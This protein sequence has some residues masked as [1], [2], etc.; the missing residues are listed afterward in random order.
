MACSCCNETYDFTK[1][2]FPESCAHFFNKDH[3][4]KGI[5]NQFNSHDDKKNRGSCLICN[6]P[7]TEMELKDILG[8][9]EYNQI[10]SK[11]LEQTLQKTSVTCIK[12]N[13]T[14]SFEPGDMNSLIKG[15]DNKPL[16]G[17][18]LKWYVENRFKCPTNNCGTE[19]C[20]TCQA[21]PYHI[22]V[23]C[24]EYKNFTPCRYCGE[25][26]EHEVNMKTNP[27]TDICMYNKGCLE[28]MENACKFVLPC[29]HRCGGIKDEKAHPE[30]L[31]EKCSEVKERHIL[32]LDCLFLRSRYDMCNKKS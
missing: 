8:E 1:L 9:N 20:K 6:L 29:G 2:F 3:L 4:K 5:E 26:L 21:S 32:N 28:K 25:G 31:Y 16:T 24:D 13:Q 22:G 12:C 14:Y 7:F 11:S 17:Q 27:F 19:Q 23:S 10:I 30:C 18:N 15:S